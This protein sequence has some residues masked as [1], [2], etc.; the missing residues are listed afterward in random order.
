[1][2]FK[3]K[4]IKQLPLRLA[5]VPNA[6]LHSFYAGRNQQLL[7][8]IQEM[9]RGHL[10]PFLF[11]WGPPG[12]GRTHLLQGAC[13]SATLCQKTAF[14]VCLEDQKDPA[15]LEGLEKIELVCIDNLDNIAGDRSWEEALFHLFNRVTASVHRLLIAAEV[16]P[17]SLRLCLPD[18][19]SRLCSG[20]T[21][22]LHPL[23]E[24]ELFLALQT[25]AQQRGLLLSREVAT[26]LLRRCV[27]SMAELSLCLEQ[28]DKASLV[29][30]RRLTIPFVK[31]VLS[32]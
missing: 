22:Q 29:E 9:V 15:C 4:A 10:D 16:P 8:H 25:Q 26:F 27:R 30:Q 23:Q 11:L 5:S 6:T 24:E 12:S 13:H 7:G 19:Q 2:R 3:H 28:L 21:Y 17:L 18:L 31:S 20:V 14:Y 1:M 32:L